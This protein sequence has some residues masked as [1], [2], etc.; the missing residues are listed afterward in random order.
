MSGEPPVP[1][2]EAA[3]VAPPRAAPTTLGDLPPTEPADESDIWWGS[4]SS[5][6]ML[7]SLIV[8][9]V[10]T[11]GLVIGS[12]LLGQEYHLGAAVMRHQFYG[13]ASLLWSIQLLLW[14]YRV[15]G[16]HYRLTTRR[17]F[18]GQGFSKPPAALELTDVREVQMRQKALECRLGVGQVCVTDK[19][20]QRM[21]LRGVYDPERVAALI[22][23]AVERARRASHR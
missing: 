15:L 11:A 9:L 2:G 13:P 16:L 22:E 4:Y 20:S 7:P 5:R 18:C 12:W 19:S 23:R 8:C 1:S 17:L 14:G 21:V 3:S 6:K 10:L